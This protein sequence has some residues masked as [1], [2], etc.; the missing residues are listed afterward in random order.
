LAVGLGYFGVLEG[1]LK[2]GGY[3]EKGFLGAGAEA[4][5]PVQYL[6]RRGG[7]AQFVWFCNDVDNNVHVWAYNGSYER[8]S[9]KKYLGGKA[10]RKFGDYFRRMYPSVEIPDKK[11]EIRERYRRDL[12]EGRVASP[13]PRTLS[14]T[15]PFS[16]AAPNRLRSAPVQR[17]SKNRGRGS[18]PQLGSE[19][20]FLGR[21]PRR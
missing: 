5:A 10:P 14:T 17:P 18:T 21:L 12:A 4:D 2:Y 16:C 13:T 1:G 9:A 8:I 19:R 6:A 20:S 3:V 11:A 7:I 15:G